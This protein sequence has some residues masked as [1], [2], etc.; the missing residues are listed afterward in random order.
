MGDAARVQ[1][2]PGYYA[3]RE[4][5]EPMRM[6]LSLLVAMTL[7]LVPGARAD[8]FSAAV[9]ADHPLAAEAGAEMLRKGGNAVDA[10]VASAFVLSVVEPYA[11][12]VGGGGFMLLSL[13]DDPRTEAENDPLR[14]AIDF[15]ETAPAAIKPNYYNATHSTASRVGGRAV[16]V[17]SMVAGLLSAHERFGALDRADVL[18][19]AIRCANE[20]FAVSDDYLSTIDE[21]RR[22]FRLTLNYKDAYSYVWNDLMGAGELEEGAALKNPAQG[23]LLSRIS[24]HGA[25]A[26]YTGEVAEAI[27]SVVSEYGGEMTL[28]DLADYKVVDREPL[29]G[30]FAGREILTMPPPSSGGVATLQILGLLE[31]YAQSTETPLAEYEHNSVPWMHALAEA[32]KHAFADRNAVMGDPDHADVDWAPLLESDYLDQLAARTDPTAALKPNEYGALG[33]EA[34]PLPDDAGTSHLSVIDASGGAVA[35]TLTINTSF[36]SFVAVEPFGFVLNNEMDDF[37]TRSGR[38][39][40]FG[41]KQSDANAPDAGKRPVS[42]MSPTIVLDDAGA[43][44]LIAGASGGPRIITATVQAIL[45]ALVFDMSAQ[46]AVTAPRVHDQLWPPALYMEPEWD[47]GGQPDPEDIEKFTR[48]ARNS[49]RNTTIRFELTGLGHSLRRMAEIGAV[50][51]IK[52]TDEGY[53]AAGDPRKG[54]SGAGVE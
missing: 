34:E 20:G 24:E 54:G 40:A 31:R 9:A 26:F 23:E 8:V 11:C 7:T 2:L 37:T 21:L 44:E 36:G 14:L 39:N 15:R 41:L 45:N 12:G 18:A 28:K 25:D 1:S 51:V 19:P 10:A 27:V 17:P 46:D 38:P 53:E 33:L 22:T 30:A 3:P 52:R 32:F 4:R 43:V 49:K 48:W 13:P 42:S 47:L 35:C 5:A 29:V 50:Q 16:A 6:I